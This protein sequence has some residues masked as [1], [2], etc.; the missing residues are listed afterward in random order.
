MAPYGL[1]L[2]GVDAL[3]P[4][5]TEE[6]LDDAEMLGS[7]F[8]PTKEPVFPTQGDG[9][10]LSFDLVCVY[11]HIGIFQE[12]LEGTLA[13]ADIEESLGEGVAG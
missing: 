1:P 5:R 7:E 13:A 8:R 12:D 11:G 2:T 4:A 10:N 6:A 3:E 9:A